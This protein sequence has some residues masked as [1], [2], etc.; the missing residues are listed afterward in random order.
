VLAPT[1][2]RA[3]I[4]ALLR[5]GGYSLAFRAP[6]PGT[7]TVGW[8][9]LVHGRHRLLASGSATA[10][11]PGTLLIKVKLTRTAK[12]LLRASRSLSVTSRATFTPDGGSSTTL[13]ATFTLKR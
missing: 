9:M 4:A 2:R 6:S 8:Y 10:G 7:L 1:G 5:A 13:T 3:R 11:R 12:K